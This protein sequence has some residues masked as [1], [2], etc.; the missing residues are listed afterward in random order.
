MKRLLFLLFFPFTAFAQ[1]NFYYGNIHSHTDYSD[2]NKDSVASGVSTPWGSYIYAKSSYHVD[3]WG[4]SEH[5][6]FNANNNPGMLLA[7]YAAGLYQADIS[8]DNGSFVC[9]Y[10]MEFGTISQ[11]GH[12]VTYGSPGLIGWEDVGGSPN[13]D[14]YCPLNDYPAYWN[15]IN[16]YPNAFT[17][18]AHPEIHDYNELLDGAPFSAAADK[19]IVGCA[20][21]SGAAFS[22][23]DDYSDPPASSYEYRYRKC[24]ASGYHVGPTIDH[25]NHYTNFGRT[26]PGRTVVLSTVLHRDSII[27]AYKARRFYASDDW[28]T[29]VDYLIN[30]ACMGQTITI[31]YNSNISVSVSDVDAADGVSLIEI[32]YGIPGSGVTSTLLTSVSNSNTLSYTHVTQPGESYY[33]YAKI[34]Q[35]DNDI[36]WTAPVW[37]NRIAFPLSAA[38][39]EA[40]EKK[41]EEDNFVLF[42]NPAVHK[43][44]VNY[45][46]TEQARAMVRIYNAEGRQVYFDNV[47]IIAGDN[48]FSYDISCFAPGY[49]YYVLQAENKRLVDRGFV[50]W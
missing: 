29:K 46:A 14:T 26:L 36:I 37:I 13:Y 48:P 10:G 8:N 5:N 19:A 6:H 28:N 39:I 27:A 45:K 3:F 24:L 18:L 1:Y 31:G 21:R 16:T 2:G 17:T 9:M 35:T 11:G 30:G 40:D 7:N 44:S 22:T 23:T 38:D 32:Y 42:P 43:L 12:V 47:N 49:Y 15:I 33:Y 34:T 41:N 4:I 25:D 20:V 50:K